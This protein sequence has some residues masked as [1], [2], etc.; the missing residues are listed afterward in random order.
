MSNELT[1]HQRSITE[2]KPYERN[3]RKNDAAV[4]AVARSIKEFGF[5]QP[6]VVD[7][8]GVIVVGHTRFKA[9][10]QLGLAE[11]P[12]H[13]AVG[14]TEEQA[15]AYRIADN[16]TA[17]LSTF[18]PDLLPLELHDLQAMGVDLALTGFS[19][20]EIERLLHSGANPGLVD[21]DDIPE[22]P[23]EA[24]TQPGDMWV[25][26]NHRLLCGDSSKPE[27]LDRLLDG[28]PIHLAHVD[29]PYNVN[30]EPRS[31]NAR[32]AG[33]T[34]L[35]AV[36][37]AKAHLQGFDDARQG[38]PKATHKQMR[39]KDRPLQND[40]MS[41]ADFDAVLL[42][43]F[44]NMARVLLPGRCFYVWG[45]YANWAN[46][47]SALATCGLYFSQGITWV[48]SHP[49]LGRKDFMNDC[50]HAWYGWREGAGHRFFGPN[51][52]SNVW[53]VKKVNPQAMVHLTEKPVELAARAIVYS[54]QPGENVLDL[55]GGSGS[56]LIACEQ[57]GRRAFLLEL[58]PLY[59]DVIVQRWEQFT[60]L[61]AQRQSAR[62][63]P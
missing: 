54:S 48:K 9:A 26:G 41:A 1:V 37:K 45:G 55:F 52:I 29:P 15:K 23:A 10:Q 43:W 47:C 63:Q 5:R 8:H 13:V 3:P 49:V 21:P 50:E 17:A 22:P 60:G 4:D 40:F 42:A 62:P 25:L 53:N 33:S 38:K 20:A 51:N 28:Q 12:V 14:L 19:E 34:A 24:V 31:N 35:P 58:D 30:V 39:A 59:C 27:D 11:V 44:G 36:A 56:T 18:D 32:A 61:K 7:E 16:Q 6:V 2:I 57:Q 46:Y